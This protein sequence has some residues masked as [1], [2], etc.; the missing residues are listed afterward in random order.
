MGAETPPTI[1]P[2]LHN[3]EV[4][5][6]KAYQRPDAARIKQE[7]QLK[8]L[9]PVKKKKGQAYLDADEKWLSIAV[10]QVRQPI[11]TLFGWIEKQTGI[12]IASNVRSHQGLLVHVFGKLAAAMFFFRII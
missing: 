11:E 1:R 3:E 9:T 4:F 6:D 7:Q 10:S 5:G 2:V 12:E 8:V